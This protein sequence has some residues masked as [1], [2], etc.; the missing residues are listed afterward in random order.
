M[1]FA[2]T[3]KHKTVAGDVRIHVG[4][5]DAAGVITGNID[6]GMSY[7]Y[8]I[9]LTEHGGTT[10]AGSSG[11][12]VDETIPGAVGNA[13]TIHCKESASGTFCAIGR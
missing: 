7:L 1:T 4:T 11:V 9:Q 5:W 10:A 6:T 12:F 3:R 13:V 2:S 8:D